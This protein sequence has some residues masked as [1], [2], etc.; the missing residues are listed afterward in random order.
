MF[1]CPIPGRRRRLSAR[2]DK[3]YFGFFSHRTHA[4][5]L[6][7]SRFRLPTP[8]LRPRPRRR[9]PYSASSAAASPGA[10]RPA[11]TPRTT[12]SAMKKLSFLSR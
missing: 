10:P 9:A 3:I 11:P 2:A 8:R 12:C 4:I 6:S 5:S 1:L 7:T